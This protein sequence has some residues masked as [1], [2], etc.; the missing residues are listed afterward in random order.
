MANTNT[1]HINYDPNQKYRGN[2]NKM[3]NLIKLLLKC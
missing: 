2:N 1:A 3:N